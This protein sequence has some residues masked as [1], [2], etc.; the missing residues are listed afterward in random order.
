VHGSAPDIAGQGVA[1]PL[2]AIWSAALMLEQLGEPDAA[3]RV[4][5]AIAEV[6]R[7]GVLTRDVGGNSGTVEVG[8]AVAERI[9][10]G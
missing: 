2:G 4:H 9:R 6:C 5:N 1:N 8:D 7:R 3:A 10:S